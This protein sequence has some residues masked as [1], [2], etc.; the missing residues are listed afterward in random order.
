MVSLLTEKY[1]CVSVPW[2]FEP[3]EALPAFLCYHES[4]A[5]LMQKQWGFLDRVSRASLEEMYKM[6]YD[7]TKELTESGRLKLR[8]RHGLSA[9]RK[10]PMPTPNII[11]ISSRRGRHLTL[12]ETSTAD[13][14]RHLR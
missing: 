4:D 5:A 1:E 14:D 8:R 9:T 2:M 12:S 7:Y 10:M 3:G 11:N 13:S 6:G